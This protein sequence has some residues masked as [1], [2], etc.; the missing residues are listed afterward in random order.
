MLRMDSMTKYT[1]V[2]AGI[3]VVMVA[4]GARK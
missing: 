3:I 1:V 4:M 2:F